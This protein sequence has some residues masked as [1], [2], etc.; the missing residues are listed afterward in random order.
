[1]ILFCQM[2]KLSESILL[3]SSEDCRS[4]KNGRFPFQPFKITTIIKF[5]N[6]SNLF[7]NNS[8]KATVFIQIYW[9]EGRTFSASTRMI[10]LFNETFLISAYRPDLRQYLA[11]ITK[12]LKKGWL[13][14]RTATQWFQSLCF[15]TFVTS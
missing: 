13:F 2:L 3:H 4:S 12:A 9:D 11:I 1:V 5:S 8:C 15:V 10:T 7:H 6:K 14:Y